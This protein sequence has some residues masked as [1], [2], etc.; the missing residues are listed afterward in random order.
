MYEEV[1][2]G[3]R[4]NGEV[5]ARNQN[6]MVV[7]GEDGYTHLCKLVGEPHKQ[8]DFSLECTRRN[9]ENA[10]P[11]QKVKSLKQTGKQEYLLAWAKQRSI[12]LSTAEQFV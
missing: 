10:A 6:T 1:G 8:P 7:L 9:F 11:Q 12:I 4:I 3:A 2:T 5:T